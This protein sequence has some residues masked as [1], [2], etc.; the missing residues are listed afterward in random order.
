MPLTGAVHAAP[1]GRRPGNPTGALPRRDSWRQWPTRDD[2]IVLRKSRADLEC[3]GPPKWAGVPNPPIG[4]QIGGRE[5]HTKFTP[6]RIQVKS[7]SHSASVISPTQPQSCLTKT[8]GTRARR[9]TARA[10][11]AGT[12]SEFPIY[13]NCAPIQPWIW[14]R[15]VFEDDVRPNMLTSSLQPRL[16]AHCWSHPQVRP[17]PVPSVLP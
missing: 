3:S 7:P 6:T 9:P 8:S 17:Q 11:A 4:C 5:I 13:T 2:K 10:L 15:K 1:V 12:N 14:R 16:Q